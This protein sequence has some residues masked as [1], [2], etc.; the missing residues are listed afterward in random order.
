MMQKLTL[1]AA[2][3]LGLVGP[4]AGQPE[5]TNHKVVCLGNPMTGRAYNHNGADSG[6]GDGCYF[7]QDSPIG[8]QIKKV[9]GIGDLANPDD[10]G[11]PCQVDA[12]VDRQ[13]RIIRIIR[14]LVGD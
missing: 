1:T 12:V 7:T 14:V 2:L 11:T 6:I 9:C 3:A 10:Q 5:H 13:N 8:R 4:A